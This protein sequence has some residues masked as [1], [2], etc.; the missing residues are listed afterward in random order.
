MK[1]LVKRLVKTLPPILLAHDLTTVLPHLPFL[2]FDVAGCDAL[3]QLLAS[4]HPS[5]IICRLCLFAFMPSRATKKASA[6]KD[7]GDN[8]PAVSGQAEYDLVADDAWRDLEALPYPPES[9]CRLSGFGREFRDAMVADAKNWAESK[10]IDAKS[11]AVRAI[12]GAVAYIV[13]P[14]VVHLHEFREHVAAH[15][16]RLCAR[17]QRFEDDTIRRVEE[18]A[19]GYSRLDAAFSRWESREQRQQ[20]DL[21]KCL[22]QLQ[23]RCSQMS[24]Q[25]SELHRRVEGLEANSVVDNRL[26]RPT[27]PRARSRSASSEGGGRGALEPAEQLLSA[28]LLAISRRSRSPGPDTAAVLR[29]FSNHSRQ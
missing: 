24:L 23:A 21:E 27:R 9:Y 28:Q 18:M 3:V 4:L 10:V 2:R 11:W 29:E 6:G 12:A 13:Q 7:A 16:Q 22:E 20:E 14:R 1:R 26:P 8:P 15:L 5:R 17:R 19:A 25:I